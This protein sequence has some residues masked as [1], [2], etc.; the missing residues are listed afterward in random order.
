[1]GGLR[2]ADV[3]SIELI[4]PNRTP[5]RIFN[6]YNRN[7]LS[8]INL[9]SELNSATQ[10][11]V[12]GDLNAHHPRW[13]RAD[14]EPSEDWR[15]VF[16]IVN[17]G[18]LA[19]EPGTT[20]RIG[21]VG[22]RS[23]TIDLIIS[24]P[25]RGMDSIHATIGEDLHTGSDHEVITEELF[26]NHEGNDPINQIPDDTPAWKLRPPIKNDDTD[27]FKEWQEKWLAGKT[28]YSDPMQ[29][30]NRFTNFL[31]ETFGRK[32]WSP[33]AKRW[34]N[35]DLDKQ[36]KQLLSLP[37]HSPEF[38]A[39]RFKWFKV[40]RKAKRE[41]WENFRQESDP[42]RILKTI[43]SKPARHAIPTLRI[44]SESG[45]DQVVATHSEEVAAI[46]A[47]SFPE[48]EDIPLPVPPT[49]TAHAPKSGASASK[50]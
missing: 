12:A 10:C 39:A 27:E 14:R 48:W 8:Q 38:K 25:G 41:C 19:I 2:D 30:I 20:T 7:T 33:Y 21:S 47:I 43:N 34:W 6:I 5:V 11:I 31:D 16:P 4:Q 22:Q 40:V 44:R 24:G 1:M 28:A 42:D 26:S 35:D 36:R 3:V 49:R 17:A 15:N 32:T 23:S 9:A 50:D 45:A 29:E 37:R 18:T 46:S 13:S